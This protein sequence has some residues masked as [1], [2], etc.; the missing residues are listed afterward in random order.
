[1]PRA[2]SA[3]LDRMQAA[4]PNETLKGKG[5]NERHNVAHRPDGVGGGDALAGVQD[6]SAGWRL[7]RVFV[8]KSTSRHQVVG[9]SDH[10]K[11]GAHQR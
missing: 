10:S 7:R 1:V 6:D 8:A 3:G 4:A 5:A 9:L 11:R 2:A